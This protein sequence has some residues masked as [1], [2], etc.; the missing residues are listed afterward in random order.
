MPVGGIPEINR[1]VRTAEYD[2]SS[3]GS[4]PARLDGNIEPKVVLGAK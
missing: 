2:T 4:L 3:H 1:S